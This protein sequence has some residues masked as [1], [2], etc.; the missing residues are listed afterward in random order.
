MFMKTPIEELAARLT[1]RNQV[2]VAAELGISA[3]YLS[4][5]LHERRKPGKKILA[6]LGMERVVIYKKAKRK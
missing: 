6:A 1:D 2:A 5:V 3:Q 4:D